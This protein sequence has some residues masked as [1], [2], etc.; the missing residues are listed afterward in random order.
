[1]IPKE[2][3]PS[4]FRRFLLRYKVFKP[5]VSKTQ[6]PRGRVRQFFGHRPFLLFIAVFAVV[7]GFLGPFVDNDVLYGK[8][9]ARMRESGDPRLK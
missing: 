3:P 2:K 6:K 1:M 7:G 9:R 4:A 8:N 5:F